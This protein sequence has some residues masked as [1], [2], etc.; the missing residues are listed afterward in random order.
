MN[1][2]LMCKREEK[3]NLT[4][5]CQ[6]GEKKNLTKI[7]NDKTKPKKLKKINGKLGTSNLDAVF[8]F[9]IKDPMSSIEI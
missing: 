7:N 1:S 9:I 3:L 4:K 5:I 8:F 6:T 2:N